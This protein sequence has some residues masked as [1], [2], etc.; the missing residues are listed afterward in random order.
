MQRN[1]SSTKSI[2]DS[3]RIIQIIFPSVTVWLQYLRYILW[4]T[5]NKSIDITYVAMKVVTSFQTEIILPT[6]AITRVMRWLAVK[7]L[8][9]DTTIKQIS[10]IALEKYASNVTI[11]F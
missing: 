4:N 1:F 8:V 5:V 7:D 6:V 2:S 3:S 10:L 11:Y 9:G